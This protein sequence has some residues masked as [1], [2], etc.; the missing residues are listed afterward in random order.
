MQKS[1]RSS[2]A[3]AGP[4]RLWIRC[5]RSTVSSSSRSETLRWDIVGAAAS[6]VCFPLA[7]TVLMMR[8]ARKDYTFADGTCIP[9]G[10]TVSVNPTQAHHNPE[11]YENPEQFEGFHV[12]NM[13]LQ[14]DSK[15]MILLPPPQSS[16]LS[17]TGVMPVLDAHFT[18]CKLKIMLAHTVLRYDVKME[19]EGVR[20]PDVCLASSCLPNP[21]GKVMFRTR[22]T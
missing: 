5:T 18:T 3:G 22:A 14:Q 21:K 7:E 1:K 12:A 8:V 19:N 16:C 20:P 17:D 10:T 9:Q 2:N 6:C 15:N 11:T 4:K 13:R